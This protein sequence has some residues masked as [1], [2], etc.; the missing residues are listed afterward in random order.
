MLSEERPLRFRGPAGLE[1]TGWPS[2]LTIRLAMIV[3]PRLPDVTGR[4]MQVR[5]PSGKVR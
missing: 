5:N 4:E 1:L 3:P 2:D